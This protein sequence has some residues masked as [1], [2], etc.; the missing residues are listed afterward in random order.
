MY[1]RG[2]L[3]PETI[4]GT[5][6]AFVPV[7][8]RRKRLSKGSL[9]VP[10]PHAG[11]EVNFCKTVRC[12]NFLMP[13]RPVRPYRKSSTP[14]QPGDYTMGSSGDRIPKLECEFCGERSPVR[15]NLAVAEELERQSRYL[16]PDPKD[17]PSCPNPACDL[18]GVSL[19][20]SNDGYVRFG[21]TPAGTQRFRC[22]KCGGT[23]SGKTPPGAWQREAL[24]NRDVFLL[25]VNKVPISRVLETTDIGFDTFYRKLHFI[26]RQPV[27]G[28]RCTLLCWAGLLESASVHRL[29][30]QK[31]DRL[32]DGSLHCIHGL[33]CPNGPEDRLC[34]E[35]AR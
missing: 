19:S 6:K 7:A 26:N 29:L 30:S 14:R 21:Q 15:S 10:P 16:Q 20:E 4:S 17:D 5:G 3:A 27:P 32:L 35:A 1:L 31:L 28:R 33:R 8:P 18:H 23:F 34:G 11:I 13:P 24:K 2:F 9:R 12:E 22:K 25:I